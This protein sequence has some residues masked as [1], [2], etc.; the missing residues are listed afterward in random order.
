M[1][2]NGIKTEGGDHFIKPDPDMEEEEDKYADDEGELQIPASA[3]EM[4]VWLAKLPKWL[5]ES[6]SD[7]ADD[8]EFEIGKLRVY[9][10]RPEDLARNKIKLVLHDLP[11]GQHAK[12][13][14]K[15]DVTVNRQSY[16]NT[17]IFSEKDQ[18]GFK[19]WRPN[20]VFRKEDRQAQR[21]EAYRVNKNKRY[22][23]AIPKQVALAGCVANEV[24]I[25]AV[26]NEEYRRL[27][28]LRFKEMFAPR[29]Q[30]NFATG[31]DR[32]LHPSIA[33]SAAFATFTTAAQS[34]KPAK[35][36]QTEKAVRISQEDLIDHMTDCFKRFKYW[37]LRALKQELHQPESYIKSTIE[38]IATLVKSGPFSNNYRLNSEY[39][40]LVDFDPNSV[41]EEAATEDVDDVDV[42]FEGDGDGDDF[43][44]VKMEGS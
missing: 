15:Y 5:W 11:N 37:S 13:P 40:N 18:P 26:E 38:K 31:V 34:G 36:K 24:T 10:K 30:T 14:K 9:D 33:A 8:E 23:S 6:W 7:M 19:S 4:N 3:G 29:R 17:V 44:D 39:G 16:S 22:S 2:M 21:E 20:R 41:K 28:D 32:S 25:T 42:D 35:K 43:E 12:V 1:A 27:T